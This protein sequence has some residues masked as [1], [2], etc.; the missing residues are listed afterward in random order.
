MPWSTLAALATLNL[1]TSAKAKVMANQKK[2]Y[3]M[4]A[5]RI[6]A[7][8]Q[9]RKQVPYLMVAKTRQKGREAKAANPQKH[10]N[11]TIVKP[12]GGHTK[13]YLI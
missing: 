11:N 12:F 5:K 3:L 4:T 9:E 13:S 1:S 8:P 7:K 2:V 10:G 6:V